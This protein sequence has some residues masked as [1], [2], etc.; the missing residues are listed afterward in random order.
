LNKKDVRVLPN[1]MTP[2][3]PVIFDETV[4]T[5][6][7]NC[8]NV[9]VMDVFMP[10][11]DKGKPP[12]MVYPDECWYDG[13]CVKNCPFWEKG[14]IKL[15]HPMNQRARW[16]RKTT[17]EL[18]RIGMPNPPPPNNRPPAGGWDPKA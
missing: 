16:K 13:L 10:N 17:G 8:V 4:C 5:G 3:N 14:A 18:F 7:N 12:V 15:N 11:P 1:M 2:S 9:C 6:C